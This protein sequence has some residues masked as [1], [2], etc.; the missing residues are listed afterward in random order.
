MKED[1]SNKSAGAIYEFV[2]LNSNAKETFLGVF[3]LAIG[4]GTA[5]LDIRRLSSSDDRWQTRTVDTKSR[6]PGKNELPLRIIV[7]K[8]TIANKNDSYLSRQ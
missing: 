5:V 4:S 3:Y 2:E 1:R 8:V 6:G 7:I